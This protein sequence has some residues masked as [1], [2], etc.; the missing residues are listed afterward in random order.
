[1]PAEAGCLNSILELIGPNPM[2]EP[3]AIALSLTDD[4]VHFTAVARSNPRIDIDYTPPLGT[5][6]GYLPLELFLASLAA[7][8]AATIVTLLRRMQR[9]IVSLDAQAEG[10]R[11]TEH[12]TAFERIELHLS[13]VSDDATQQ[14]VEKAVQ[15]SRA[16]YCPVWA[17]LKEDIAVTVHTTILPVV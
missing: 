11:R 4:K 15:L 14:D 9:T 12:P 10:I 7:C 5:G 2:S 17:M 3:L 13:I 6:D 1:V 16:T 8:S